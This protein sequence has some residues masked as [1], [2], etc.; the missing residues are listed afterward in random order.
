MLSSNEAKTIGLVDEVVKKDDLLSIAKK[1]IEKW[2]AIPG[3]Y[4][5]S[6]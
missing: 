5:V 2:L 3:I 6:L 1:E 4:I